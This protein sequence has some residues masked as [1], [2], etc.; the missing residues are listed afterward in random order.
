MNAAPRHPYANVS[1]CTMYVSSLIIDGLLQYLIAL[2]F[3]TSFLPQTNTL[4]HEPCCL[5][6]IQHGQLN[7]SGLT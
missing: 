4:V 7:V 2:E 5:A 6:V 1:D 3:D